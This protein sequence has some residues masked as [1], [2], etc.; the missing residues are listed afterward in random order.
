MRARFLVLV[1]ILLI[2]SCGRAYRQEMAEKALK[3]AEARE[4]LTEE[5]PGLV[6]ALEETEEM[7][8][9]LELLLQG[10]ESS[11]SGDFENTD[12]S[13]R[14]LE[15][16]LLQLEEDLKDHTGELE[17]IRE[18]IILPV[19]DKALEESSSDAPASASESSS[20]GEIPQD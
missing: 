16:R 6:E 3:D 9:E 5:I 4:D 7:L 13:I 19:L 12:R 18:E 17:K 11:F 15:D 14:D 20:T 2:P 10:E 1:P 8:N